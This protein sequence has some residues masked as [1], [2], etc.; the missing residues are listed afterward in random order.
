MYALIKM[1]RV[2]TL[3]IRPTTYAETRAHGVCVVG[4]GDSHPVWERLGNVALQ[5]LDAGEA[6]ELHVWESEY[7]DWR[8]HPCMLGEVA[9]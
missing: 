7:A 3:H 4:A 6:V 2:G 5:T 1:D 9:S 8:P